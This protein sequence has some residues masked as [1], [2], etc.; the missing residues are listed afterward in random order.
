MRPRPK[1]VIK[2]LPPESREELFTQVIEASIPYVTK[3]WEEGDRLI[4]KNGLQC[5]QEILYQK[6]V[7]R[8]YYQCNPHFWQC[9]WQGGVNKRTSIQI[10]LFG[11]TFSVTAKA[12]FDPIKEYSEQ[13][14]FYRMFK[15]QGSGLKHHYGY[16]VELEVTEIP[17]YSQPMIL[18]DTCRDVYLPE[19]VYGYGRPKDPRD[20]GFTWDNFG[21]NLFLDKFYVTNQQVNDWRVL[22]GV[23]EKINKDKASWP[24]PALIDFE[25][26][27]A[28]CSFFG[29][30]VLEAK[31]F[32]AA[33]MSPTD[34]KNP[35]PDRIQRPST[36]WQR[37]LGKTFLGMSRINS[38]YQLTPLDCQL[39]QVKGCTE[40]YFTTDS[41]T[42]MGFNFA[43]GYY[44]ESLVNFIEPK[45]NLKASSKLLPASAKEHELGALTSWNGK[46]DP[47]LP[48]S[49]RCYE[50]VSL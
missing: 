45:K 8:S 38:D 36:P 29:K 5:E 33:S 30:R 49:F 11:Q 24:R 22:S 4:S 34:L 47:E 9:Y 32:D 43:I 12:S 13:E 19:R 37:D 23:T 6:D 15:R 40:N 16:V 1:F 42:W 26:Q 27:K 2:A 21:R 20:D 10:D 50:E 3:L 39:A 44:P 31:L 35:T 14:R 46:Q 18:A 25:E 7:G 41:A 28:Y 17:G 48:V